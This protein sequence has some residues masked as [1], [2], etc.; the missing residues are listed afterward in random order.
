[1]NKDTLLRHI[2]GDATPDE[3]AQVLDWIGKSDQNRQY[4]I[5]LKNLWVSQTLPD[6]RATEAELALIRAR[7]IR[8][9]ERKVSRILIWLP[10]AIAAAAMLALVLVLT[11][12]SRNSA[13]R[14]TFAD[15]PT[16]YKHTVYT[17]SGVKSHITLPDG[18]KV[19]L[20]SET[21]LTYPDQ[22]QGNRREIEFSGE[23]YFEVAKDTLH[24][25]HIFTGKDFDVE[26]LG[27]SFNLKC[28]ENDV[29]A[30]ATLYTGHIQLV[31][32]DGQKVDI[33][34][35]QTCLIRKKHSYSTIPTVTILSDQPA[36]A[37]KQ[38][39]WKEG[40]LVFE[41]TPMDEVVKMLR[42]WHG[43]EIVVK[44]PAILSYRITAEFGSE[45]IAQIAG[46][47]RYTARIDYKIEDNVVYFFSR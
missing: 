16:E 27:T 23:A 32:K 1:M 22:F 21:T 45:S 4:Y 9:S 35:D 43:V 25:M 41:Q 28:Y 11:I 15:I 34:P 2:Q 12:P 17:E 30:T 7:T 40:R 26:V 44:D 24:P 38:S 46:M 20:N 19:W 29:T 33:A 31:A 47:L 13:V 10:T 39:A 14:Y 6:T 36:V 8:K 3:A 18:S 5:E 42:R 37:Q